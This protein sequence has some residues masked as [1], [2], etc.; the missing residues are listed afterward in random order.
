MFWAMRIIHSLLA[1]LADIIVHIKRFPT[2][3]LARPYLLHLDN[4]YEAA[5]M[6]NRRQVLQK[7]PGIS[8]DTL[9]QP[10]ENPSHL[11]SLM[12]WTWRQQRPFLCCAPASS[13]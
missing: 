1:T 7:P 12:T 11:S 4:F 3:H 13:A 5:T 2:I 8:K 10:F 6:L 9:L